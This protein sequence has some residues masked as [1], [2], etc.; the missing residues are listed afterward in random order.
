MPDDQ[1]D[2]LLDDDVPV[3][4]VR[5]LAN[6]TARTLAEGRTVVVVFE[7]NLVQ[8]AA[9]GTTVVLKPM[10]PRRKV[11]PG[12]VYQRDTVSPKAG[13]GPS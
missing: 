5:A 6:A 2:E 8:Q 9:D 4:A 10:P 11:V 3:Q 7:N 13:A 1:T 12:T